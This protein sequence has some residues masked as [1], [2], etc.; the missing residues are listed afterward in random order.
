MDLKNAVVLKKIINGKMRFRISPR[1][2]YYE[3]DVP[4][5]GFYSNWCGSEER[6]WHAA[7]CRESYRIYSS[8]FD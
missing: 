7:K 3:G 4:T 8:D 1:E 6:A 2:L 5:G